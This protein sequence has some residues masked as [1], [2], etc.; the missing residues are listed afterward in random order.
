MEQLITFKKTIQKT[1]PLRYKL[2]KKGGFCYFKNIGILG[3]GLIGGSIV[4]TLKL[5]N[6]NIRLYTVKRNNDKD[7]QIANKLK[8]LNKICDNYEE[9]LNK[10]ELIIIATPIE[11]II[12]IAKIIYQTNH[13]KKKVIVIDVGSIKGKIV[14][15]F[16]KLTND[17][18]FIG[19]H[20]MAGGDKSGFQNSDPFLFLNYLW[21]ITPHRKNKKSSIVKIKKFIEYLGAKSKILNAKDHD[22]FIGI[23]SHLIFVISTYLF[24]FSIEKYKKSLEFSGK[25][26]KTTTRLASAN[27]EMHHQIFINN[28]RNIQKSL[29][30]F[31]HFI[32]EN[33]ITKSNSL[34]IF[35]KY[36]LLRDKFYNKNDFL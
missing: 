34:K 25:G 27:P 7:I 18:E 5:K 32:K 35:K 2:L 11:T 13:L 23:V 17:F 12:P 29:K 15:E 22:R 24:A 19:T 6:K 3:L 31:L 1:D 28:Y 10:V 16:E 4:K 30:E 26:F 14:N 33:K 9:F 20:P 36:K 8:F 21:I